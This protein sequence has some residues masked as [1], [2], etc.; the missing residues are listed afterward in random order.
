[1][2][3]RC[4]IATNVAPFSSDDAQSTA[5][6][7]V[8][9]RIAYEISNHLGN[10]QAVIS[11]KKI[12]VPDT[13]DP[14]IVAFYNPGIIAATDYYPFGMVISNRSVDTEKYRYGFNGQQKDDEIAH[15][16]SSGSHNFAEFWMYDTRT[17]RRWNLDPKPQISISDYATFAN[18]PILLEDP[19][20]DK[21]IPA[22][23][24]RKINRMQR[25]ATRLAR[26]TNVTFE[27]ALQ[28]MEDNMN[29]KKRY[30][31]SRESEGDKQSGY[32]YYDIPSHVR[33]R[34]LPV[35]NPNNN[36]NVAPTTAQLIGT[37]SDLTSPTFDDTYYQLNQLGNNLTNMSLTLTN[38]RATNST[39]D[40]TNLEVTTIDVSG[41]SSNIVSGAN[42]SPGNTQVVPIPNGTAVIR[43]S[44]DKRGNVNNNNTLN[45]VTATL[46]FSRANVQSNVTNQTYAIAR[47]V[48]SYEKIPFNQVATL[49][50]QR[51][52]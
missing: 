14:T 51:F 2:I 26:R 9:G 18:S 23:I 6:S 20:G 39:T 28:R 30:G 11:D 1:M 25:Q 8:S 40:P 3:N 37:S 38:V 15:N 46:T 44:Y 27:T 5:L 42:I 49:F 7:V 16:E 47:D 13:Q 50:S 43:V 32:R 19:L 4:E 48:W 12:P 34:R 29:P 21:P 24:N 22:K 35:N 10:V 41:N 17:A 33:S 36:V 52:P 45:L 31:R